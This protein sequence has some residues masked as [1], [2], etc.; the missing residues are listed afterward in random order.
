VRALLGETFRLLAAHLNLFTLIS[1]TVWLPAHVLRNYL[2]F[3]GPPEAGP[4]QSLRVILAVQIVFD[5]LVVSATVAALGRIKQGLPVGYAA[6]MSE[7]LAAWGRLLLVRFVINVGVGLPALGVLLAVP[8]QGGT[9]I[10]AGVLCL[11]LAVL[12][13]VLLVRF[14]VVDSVVVLERATPLSAWGRAAALTAGQ[15]WKILWTLVL[16]F[17]I[18]LSFAFLVTSVFRAAPELNH[19]VPRVLLDCVV[20][21]SQS[22]FS[23]A[24]FL[25]YWRA[26][27]RES[28]ALPAA[29][30]SG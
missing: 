26:R 25:F 12:T 20:A 22:L 8:A 24:L 11:A 6:A 10:A 15:R 9:A 30:S 28:A 5:P 2:E 3:F 18:V 19:F 27:S 7:G 4:G 17:L 1:L 29:L 13:T 16:L 14:A 21:V 23:I